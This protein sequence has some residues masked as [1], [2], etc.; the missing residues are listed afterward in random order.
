MRGL[1]WLLHVEAAFP[2]S[3]AAWR[4]SS[5]SRAVVRC[6]RGSSPGRGW[7]LHG[8]HVCLPQCGLRMLHVPAKRAW[9]GARRAR[10]AGDDAKHACR[11][12]C[13]ARGADDDAKRAHALLHAERALPVT[14]NEM[15]LRGCMLKNS[16]YVL[17]LVVYTGCE[18]RI[19]MNAAATPNKVGA[20]ALRSFTP[21][22][23]AAMAWPL[24]WALS[25]ES[26]A[27]LMH[28][29]PLGPSEIPHANAA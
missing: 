22:A 25:A 28:I 12:A 19:Q 9:R 6:S 27:R 2:L 21:S 20:G 1:F 15:L 3:Q 29:Q 4:L 5:C 24:R 11:G 17:G 26:G 10:V 18:S 13:R 8:E 16:N 23:L 14:M 7:L